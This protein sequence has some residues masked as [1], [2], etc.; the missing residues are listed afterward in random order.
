M[1]FI[2]ENRASL[3]FLLGVVM[4]TIIMLRR[5]NR[6]F[7]R[8][9]TNARKESRASARRESSPEQ[10]L[11][12]APPEVL[13]WQVEMHETARELKAELDT[14]IAILQ[15]LTIDAKRESDRLEAIIEK[16]ERTGVS[17]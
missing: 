1:D 9:K 15:R 4:L 12:D 13:R 10:R 3:L 17:V 14:K 2:W 5:W 7:K 6:Y 16:A 11:L 8:Q